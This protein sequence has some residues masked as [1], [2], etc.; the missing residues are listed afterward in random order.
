LCAASTPHPITAQHNSR[1]NS[2]GAAAGR[3]CSLPEALVKQE[4]VVVC[5]QQLQSTQLVV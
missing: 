1:N 4:L 5:I 3:S 2:A